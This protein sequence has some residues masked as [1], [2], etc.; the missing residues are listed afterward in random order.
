MKYIINFEMNIMC[1]QKIYDPLRLQFAAP[2][3]SRTCICLHYFYTWKMRKSGSI[4]F[5]RMFDARLFK[6]KQMFNRVSPVLV[7]LKFS[8]KKWFAYNNP[9]YV[10]AAWYNSRTCDVNIAKSL[11]RWIITY[12]RYFTYVELRVGDT[13]GS[14]I[15]WQ[16]CKISLQEN[17]TKF[18]FS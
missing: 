17:P 6:P 8:M 18:E 7:F 9:F 16:H 5:R 2:S 4:Y 1:C 15:F 11:T 13:V 12:A 10:L 3:D 14:Q